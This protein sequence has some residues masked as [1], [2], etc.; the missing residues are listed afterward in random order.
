MFCQIFHC[1][2]ED[3]DHQ[4]V[5]IPYFDA[6]E[7]CEEVEYDECREVNLYCFTDISDILPNSIFPG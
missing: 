1:S 2:Y 3:C 4:I 7:T 5:D 6:E